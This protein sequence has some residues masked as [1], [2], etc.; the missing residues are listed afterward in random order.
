MALV[1]VNPDSLAK[2]Q[3][4]SHGVKGTGELLFVAGQIGWNREGRMVSDDLTTQ[5]AQVYSADDPHLESDVQF[6][7]TAPLVGRYV[8]HGDGG[9]LLEQRF[10]LQA[11]ESRLPAPPISGRN[12]GPRPKLEVLRR[13]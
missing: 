8:A 10:V 12:E 13:R 11:G 1:P 5:F 7:V 9:W 2:P 4:F 6:A 3:G